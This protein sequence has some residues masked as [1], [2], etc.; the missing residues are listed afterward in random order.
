MD[1]R[2]GICDLGLKFIKYRRL[3]AKIQFKRL[4]SHITHLKSIYLLLLK[5]NLLLLFNYML[6]SKPSIGY[7]VVLICTFLW[8]TSLFVPP[9]LAS[10]GQPSSHYAYM[11]FSSICHQY[12]SR[13]LH[14]AGHPLAVCARCSGIYFGFL[15]GTALL[16]FLSRKNFRQTLLLLIVAAS[17]MF[18]DVALGIVSLHEPTMMTRLFTGLFFGI[19]SAIA[20]VPLLENA[21]S[22]FFSHTF[23]IQGVNYEPET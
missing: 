14:I 1:V 12:N 10:W 17:P 22:Q 15:T 21:V 6:R 13:S 7:V 4:I 11:F 5:K 18:I 19:L 9:M 3:I 16:P 8:C 20:L 2:Y 23:H